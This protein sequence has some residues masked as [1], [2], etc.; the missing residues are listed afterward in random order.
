[1]SDTENKTLISLPIA[2]L[3]LI[4]MESA[5]GL[6][7]KINEQLSRYRRTEHP[8]ESAD[9]TFH[10]YLREDYRLGFRV[11]RSPAGEVHAELLES[12]RGRDV[13]ILTDVMNHSITYPFR[14][15][16]NYMSPDDHYSD[17]KRM[18]GAIGGKARR[19]TVIMPFLYEGR[20]HKRAYR[21]S[22]DCAVMIRELTEMGVVNF[23]TFDAHD[24]RVLNASPLRGFDSFNASYQ[25]LK[26]LLYNIDDLIVDKEHL[27]V[28]S[29]DEGALDRTVY[30]ADVLGA[31][32]GMFYKR[33]DYS[34]IEN[35]KNPIV[36]HEYLGE[37]VEGKDVIVIDDM[38]SSG[39]SMIDTAEQIKG[40]GAKRVFLCATFGLFT[41]GF[42]IFD[43][44]F[45]KGKFD[46]VITTNLTWQDPSIQEREWFIEADMSRFIAMVIDFLNHNDSITGVL[47]PTDKIHEF[48]KKYNAG[49]DAKDVIPDR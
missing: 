9:P 10:D 5:A 36:A 25:F 46:R 19:V 31:D 27:T 45:A 8:M 33:R 41:D 42:G 47:T 13:Y 26:A 2:P 34:R 24:P 20:Q 4:V 43:E 49:A 16:E 44:A 3:R 17:V 29:P 37:T 15:G 21:E 22:L 12:A 40:M 1:M 38:I 30:F 14:G 39:A 6:G 23:I 7:A 48:V 28:I 11:D 32:T 35:G 18:I